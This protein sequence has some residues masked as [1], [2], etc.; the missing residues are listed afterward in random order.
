MK[1]SFLKVLQKEGNKPYFN[2][3]LKALKLIELSKINIYPFQMDLFKPLEFFQASETKVVI[4]GQDPYHKEGVADGLAF[5]TKSTVTPPS[6]R[7]MFKELL[8]DYP[9]TKIETNDLTA[10]AKQNVLLMNVVWTVSE[11]K[12]N[13]HKNFG[14][15]NFSLAI[16][17][18]VLKANP[19]VIFVILGK[20][21]QKF[22]EKLAINPENKIVLSHPSPYSYKLGFE[23]GKM[24]KLINKKLKKQGLSEIKWDLVKENK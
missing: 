12:P 17:E 22:T 3:L 10:W 11:N 14:W 24:F 9:K 20:E 23:N 13:S 2:D 5:S 16:L 1:D 7:N 4:L 8:K 19:N 15:Q 18:E 6:L 21:A